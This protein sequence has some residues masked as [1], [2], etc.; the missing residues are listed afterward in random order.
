MDGSAVDVMGQY[1]PHISMGLGTD[2]LNGI[3]KNDET[4]M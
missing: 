1:D 3:A 2:G 4:E